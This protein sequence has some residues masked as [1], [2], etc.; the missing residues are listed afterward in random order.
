MY[1]VSIE[2]IREKERGASSLFA[3]ME[4][5]TDGVRRRAFDYY[6]RR[7][8]MFGRDLDDWLR[9]ER[10][11]MW[12]PGA[13]MTETDNDV[14]LRVQAPGLE[15][16]NIKVTATPD[17]ILIE[18]E[19]S[20]RHEDSNG[21]IRLCEFAERLFRRLD[22]PEAIDLDKVSASLDKGILQIVATKAQAAPKGRTVP[23][24]A[25]AGVAA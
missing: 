6:L 4:R 3:Q 23:V 13:E 19:V 16:H 22:M 2:K 17:S 8:S 24:A 10:E 9:A 21:K 7:G 5:L 15:P 11:L 20:H 12:T 25:R 18:G 14:I 1:N